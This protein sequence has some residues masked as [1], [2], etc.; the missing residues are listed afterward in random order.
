M[1]AILPGRHDYS[2]DRIVVEDTDEHPRI[3]VGA[4]FRME[5]V[6]ESGLVI[7]NGL[8]AWIKARMDRRARA[9]LI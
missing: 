8:P 2:S 7:I 3:R 1:T 4:G 6:L 9:R 5:N